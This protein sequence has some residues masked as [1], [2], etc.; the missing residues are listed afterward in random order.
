MA[1]EAGEAGGAGEAS[2][3]WPAIER[4]PE[5]HMRN[6]E[7]PRNTLVRIPWA[8]LNLAGQR[9]PDVTRFTKAAMVLSPPWSSDYK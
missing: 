3:H 9:N 7:D 4:Q 8:T 1:G 2:S 6:L 5:G